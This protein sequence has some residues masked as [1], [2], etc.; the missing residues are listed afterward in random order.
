MT[1]DTITREEF[2]SIIY[3][4]SHKQTMAVCICGSKRMPD[5][6]SR[7]YIMGDLNSF[8]EIIDDKWEET[9]KLD[10]VIL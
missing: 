5:R 2:L 9:K 1:S 7:D 4:V 6:A 8:G 3:Q 10:Q